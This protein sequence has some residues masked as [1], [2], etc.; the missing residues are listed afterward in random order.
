MYVSFTFSINHSH[1]RRTPPHDSRL[2][3][4]FQFQLLSVIILVQ[5]VYVLNNQLISQSI[6]QLA[7]SF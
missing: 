7:V 5:Y 4:S 6:K 3:N 2:L 1:Y